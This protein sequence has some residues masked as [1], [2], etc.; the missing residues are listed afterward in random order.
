TGALA[1][2][3]AT[4]EL[5]IALHDWLALGAGSPVFSDAPTASI[6]LAAHATADL[7]TPIVAIDATVSKL[8]VRIPD[9]LERSHQPEQQNVSADIIYVDGTHPPGALPVPVTTAAHPKLPLDIRIHIPRPVH[10]LKTPLDLDARGELTVTV[11]D[12][13]VA[14]RGTLVT[15]GGMLQ[16][17]GRDHPVVDGTLVFTD[18]HPHGEFTLHFTHELPPD[19]LRELSRRVPTHVTI[20]GAPAKPVVTLGGA[21][22]VTL[23]EVLS[24]YH[25]GHPVFEGPPGLYASSTP[26]LPHGDQY[27][28]F[29][30][31]ANALPSYLFLDRV[32][33]WADPSEPRGGYGRIRNL[34]VDRYN[35]DRSARVRVVGRPTT[36]GRSTGELQLDHLWIDSARVLFGAGLRAGDRLGGGLGLFFEWS[37]AN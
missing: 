25:A 35:A 19:A 32:F 15:T 23:D 26:E 8:D 11:R 28:V 33:A 2:R 31:I 36:P 22:N 27:L 10:V 37:S 4:G 16:L 24:M 9:R 3:P 20:T 7:R 34:E 5:D 6:D 1:L 17:F 29:G 18:D 21:F 14:T 12:T 30:Y 13:G